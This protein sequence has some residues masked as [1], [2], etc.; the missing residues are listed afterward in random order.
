MH[1]EKYMIIYS[2]IPRYAFICIY[3]ILFTVSIYYVICMS[4]IYLKYFL[5]L[6]FMLKKNLWKSPVHDMGTPETAW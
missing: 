6:S 4:P 2:Y 3:C 1:M 5:M